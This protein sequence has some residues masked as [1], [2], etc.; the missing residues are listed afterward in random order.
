[1]T[2]IAEA[3][4]RLIADTPIL[5]A[6]GDSIADAIR[7]AANKLSV[8]CKVSARVKDPASYVGKCLRKSY[9]DPWTDVTDKVGVRVTV[10][11]IADIA[12]IEKVVAEHPAFDVIERQDKTQELWEQRKIGY[13]GLHLQVKASNSDSVGMACEIQVRT[14]AQNLWSEMDHKLVYKPSHEPDGDTKRALHR[15]AALMEIFDEEVDRRMS[16]IAA[17]PGYAV[18]P[19]IDACVRHFYM[20]SAC[21]VDRP[22][23][24]FVLI[25]LGAALPDSVD[26]AVYL[27]RLS[28]FVSKYKDK[29]QRIYTRYET[30]KAT[31]SLLI[32][33]PESILIFERLDS[34]PLLFE[35]E[36]PESLP[37][38]EYDAL[39][40]IWG[41]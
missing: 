35:E 24:R 28:V 4:D 10:D 30:V 5:K 14:A 41:S 29:L 18:E 12:R 13:L 36:W 7:S 34:A 3:R 26:L 40:A 27:E 16:Q 38:Y 9:P 39:K 19:L 25:E 6:F 17:A 21:A 22:L 32:H 20:F 1:M 11:N 31:P 8:S 15:L 37:I 33:Q 2:T 23:S